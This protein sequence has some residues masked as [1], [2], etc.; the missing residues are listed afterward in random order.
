K[1]AGMFIAKRFMTLDAYLPG[2]NHPVLSSNKLKRGEYYDGNGKV[3]SSFDDLRHGVYGVDGQ[4]VVSPED[5]PNLINRDGTKHTAAKRRGIISK[6][7]GLPN[8]AIKATGKAWLGFT[9]N[10][11]KG[12]GNKLGGMFGRTAD[13]ADAYEKNWV[14]TPTDNLLNGILN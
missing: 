3:L 14:P 5:V 13:K 6:T 11:Y 12:L 1:F 2:L 9:K 7:L 10:Y 4:V 8:K